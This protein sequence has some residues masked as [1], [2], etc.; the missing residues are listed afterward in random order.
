M[1][2]STL[3]SAYPE[4]FFFIDRGECGIDYSSR[5][6]EFSLMVRP[7]SNVFQQ[8]IFCPFSG[9]PLPASLRDPFFDTLETLGFVNGIADVE[10]APEEFQSEAW[11]LSRGL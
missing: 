10:K 6:R 2:E 4:L 3:R 1:I 9:K 8:L 7:N 11:W 5:F